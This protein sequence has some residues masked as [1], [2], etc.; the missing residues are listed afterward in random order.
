MRVF[1]IPLSCYAFLR[2]SDNLLEKLINAHLLP[3]ASVILYMDLIKL[4]HC[5]TKYSL[6]THAVLCHPILYMTIGQQRICLQKS[7]EN[8]INVHRII[9]LN[10]NFAKYFGLLI[11]LLS[12]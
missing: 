5:V 2:F 6:D 10:V 11:M 8:S 3:S 7:I 1:T 12:Y 9:F 4:T